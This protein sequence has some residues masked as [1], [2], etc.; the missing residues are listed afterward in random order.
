MQNELIEYEAFYLPFVSELL[1]HLAA[2]REQVF[3]IDW[4]E[5]GQQCI[6]LLISLI[7]D[8]RA[9]PIT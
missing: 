3:V 1:A 4:S 2:I 5:V 8:K 6:T 7:Y 9:L